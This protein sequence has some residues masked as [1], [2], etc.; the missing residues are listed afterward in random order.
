MSRHLVAHSIGVLIV[1]ISAGCSSPTGPGEPLPVTRLV[2]GAFSAAETSQRLVAR[3]ETELVAAWTTLFRNFSEPPPLPT[4]DFSHDMVVIALA[5][6]KPSGGYCILVQAAAAKGNWAEI[7]IRSVGPNP[8]SALLPVVT[9]PY[10]VVRVPRREVVTFK[11]FSEVGN[12][13]PLT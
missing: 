7:M 8:S 13:G 4:V 1:L 3:S 6:T 10:D 12:C 11:E 9:N 5:G 2:Q